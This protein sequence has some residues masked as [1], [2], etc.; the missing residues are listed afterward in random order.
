M[1]SAA[2]ATLRTSP[3]SAAPAYPLRHFVEVAMAFCGGFGRVLSVWQSQPGS[4]A[5]ARSSR[6]VY[7]PWR[8]VLPGAT[9]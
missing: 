7:V 9:T 8:V 6:T 2:V 4:G 3:R 1:P 5:G